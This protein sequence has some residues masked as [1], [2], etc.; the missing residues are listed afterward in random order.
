MKQS[1]FITNQRVGASGK[2]AR[3]QNA[4]IPRNHKAVPQS[5]GS[6]QTT[7]L[8]PPV[9]EQAARASGAQERGDPRPEHP[10]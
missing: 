9:R 8:W 1:I 10:A 7:R 4:S 2:G 3:S 6:P 5:A